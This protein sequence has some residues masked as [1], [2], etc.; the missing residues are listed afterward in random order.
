MKLKT[1]LFPGRPPVVVAAGTP[2]EFSVVLAQFTHA[3]RLALLDALSGGVEGRS[4]ERIST[5]ALRMVVGVA[6]LY[7]DQGAA[8]PVVR[9]GDCEQRRRPRDSGGAEAARGG[10]GCRNGEGMRR[11]SG[12]RRAGGL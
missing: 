3:D 1:G 8:V 11:E 5:A 4:F 6:G 9:R 12:I 7:D 2:D 10:A